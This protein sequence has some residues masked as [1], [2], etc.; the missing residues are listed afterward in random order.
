[1]NAVAVTVLAF[2]MSMDA[3]AAAL[4]KGA[5]LRRPPFAEALRTG[6]VFGSIETLTPLIGWTIGAAAASWVAQVDHWIA[7][8]ILGLLGLRMAATALRRA[9]AVRPPLSRHSLPVLA[10]TGVA[11]SLDALAVGVTL[12][13]VDVNIFT[14]AVAIGLATFLMAT[15]GTVAGRWLGPLF[16]RGAELLGGVCLIGIGT[17]ILFDHTVGG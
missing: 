13:F 5:A 7:F 16:G 8:A 4:G 3:F 14:A 17:K 15:A 6:L 12:A 11:T 2:S 1:M 10:A 9:E